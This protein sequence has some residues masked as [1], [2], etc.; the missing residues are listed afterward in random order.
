MP[1]ADTIEAAFE[2]H[3]EEAPDEAPVLTPEVRDTLIDEWRSI[4][5]GSFAQVYAPD[6]IAPHRRVT[7]PRGGR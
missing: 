6:R 3:L 4:M 1:A 2:Q 5:G 7:A